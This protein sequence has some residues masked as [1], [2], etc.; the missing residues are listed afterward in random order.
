MQSFTELEAWK[1][2]LQVVQKTYAVTKVFPRE[3]LFG[4]TAQLRRAS[5]SV[6]ANIAEGFG[7]YTYADKA[8]KYTI[9]RGECSEIHALLLIVANLQF[10]SFQEI[11]DA[12]HLVTR[13]GRLLSGLIESSRSREH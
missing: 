10:I 6:L 9:A 2:G 3:E 1:I 8:N 4:L 12:I 7:R 5:V 11:Q 13:T